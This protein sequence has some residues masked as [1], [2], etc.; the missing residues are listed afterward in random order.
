VVL[1]PVCNEYKHNGVRFQPPPPIAWQ[2]MDFHKIWRER[3]DTKSAKDLQVCLPY[4]Q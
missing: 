3:H 1:H 4:K 2:R